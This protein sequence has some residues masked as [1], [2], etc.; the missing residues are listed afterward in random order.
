VFRWSGTG[1]S[2]GRVSDLDDLLAQIPTD[3]LAAR[4]G[5]DRATADAAI[6][7]TLPALVGGLHANA[8]DPA[9][10]AS[11]TGALG[12]H[13]P[14]LVEGGVDLDRVDP[15]DGDKIVGHVFGDTRGQVVQALGATGSPTVTRDLVAKLLPLLAPI[16]MSYLAKRLGG[17][18]GSAAGGTAGSNVVADILGSL[19]GAAAGS[20]HS[21]GTARTAGPGGFDLGSVLGGLGGLLGRGRR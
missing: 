13:D 2:L 9:G 11:L 16:V 4:L 21:T 3:R 8:Q 5:V 12:R 1:A 14:G 15:A 17:A 19:L 7:Q 18:Q 6:R 10:A 20:A